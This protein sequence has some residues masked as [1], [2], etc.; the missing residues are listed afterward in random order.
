MET[1]NV[2]NHD[3]DTGKRDGAA[4]FEL[5]RRRFIATSVGVSAGLAIV[6]FAANVS[7]A[8]TTNDLLNK[9]T[10]EIAK[11]LSSGSV[12]AV[13]VVTAGY[14]RIDAVNPKINAVV[15]TCRERALAEAAKADAALASGKSLGP[16][17]GVPFTVKDSFDTEGVLSTGGTLGRKN[18]IPSKDA[19]VVARA[20]AA[21]AILLGKTNTPEFT[22]G[23][24]GKGTVNLVFGLT[25]NPYNLNYQ[26]S[27]S[28][29]GAGLSASSQWST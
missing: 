28:S 3:A 26:P 17:H 12:S 25:K 22:L 16:L 10:V 2:K 21:G 8:S 4:T 6:P 19:T 24:G 7:A 29:G 14:A 11:L 9:S 15:T 27:G 18:F 1:A 23:G 5:S 13:E 20:R